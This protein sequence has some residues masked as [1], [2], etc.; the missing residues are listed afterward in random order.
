MLGADRRVL[1][2]EH[3]R[4]LDTMPLAETTGDLGGT[5]AGWFLRPRLRNKGSI[6]SDIWE[7]TATDLASRHAIAVFPTGGWWRQKPALGRAERR[8][9]YSLIVSLEAP[10]GIDLYT[11]IQTSIAPDVQVETGE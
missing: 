9:R 5:E 2:T 8:I 3:D 11:P 7:G 1:F 10:I 4:Y 6:H